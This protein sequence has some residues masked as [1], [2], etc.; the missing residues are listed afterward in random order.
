MVRAIDTEHEKVGDLT[1]PPE[2]IE[3]GI[4]AKDHDDEPSDEFLNNETSFG[5]AG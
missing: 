3:L 4:E 2:L 1:F 5:T